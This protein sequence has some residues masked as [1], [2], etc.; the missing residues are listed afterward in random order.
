MSNSDK[1]IIK[2]KGKVI[3]SYYEETQGSIKKKHDEEAKNKDLESK[4][5]KLI[6]K[7]ACIIK[8]IYVEIIIKIQVYFTLLII[9][10]L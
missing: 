5:Q 6:K 9:L 8:L 4:L 3:L 7:K 1:L 10:N 2:I